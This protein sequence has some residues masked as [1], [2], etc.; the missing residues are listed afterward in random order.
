MPYPIPRS[1]PPT[2]NAGAYVEF[3]HGDNNLDDMN[4]TLD[5]FSSLITDEIENGTPADRIVLMG[6]SQ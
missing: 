6:F 1:A 4:V 5:Y 2:T 3:G